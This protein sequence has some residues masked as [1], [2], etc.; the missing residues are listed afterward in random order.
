ATSWRRG[1]PLNAVGAG[2]SRIDGTD[3]ENE[4][5]GKARVFCGDRGGLLEAAGK[6]EPVAADELLRFDV[7]PVRRRVLRNDLSFSRK[8]L[9]RL[10]LARGDKALVPRVKPVDRVLYLLSRR[11]LVPLPTR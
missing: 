10:H 1:L 7:R 11:V 5:A 3:L 9:A 2:T 4:T 6:N 8:S